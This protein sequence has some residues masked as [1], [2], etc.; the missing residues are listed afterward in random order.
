MKEFE[1]SPLRA[2]TAAEH[3]LEERH[4]PLSGK[5]EAKIPELYASVPNRGLKLN[6]FASGQVNRSSMFTS[7]ASVVTIT[8]TEVWHEEHDPKEKNKLHGSPVV[9]LEDPDSEEHYYYTP[10]LTTKLRQDRLP[11]PAKTRRHH[12]APDHPPPKAISPH[13]PAAND[14]SL[15]SREIDG[16]TGGTRKGWSGEKRAGEGE[17]IK[18]TVESHDGARSRGLA[19]SNVHDGPAATENRHAAQTPPRELDHTVGDVGAVGNLYDV[20]SHRVG[21]VSEKNG[22]GKMVHHGSIDEQPK[23]HAPVRFKGT[24]W[25][26]KELKDNGI[27]EIEA[28]YSRRVK[29]VTKKMLMSWSER[30]KKN[31]NRKEVT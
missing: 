17:D 3:H 13:H 10:K 7:T 21:V 24:V 14:L 23:L 29:K 4:L 15:A 18:V 6:D 20:A 2:K 28:P 16:E 12:P 27:I 30:K 1:E 26:V 8:E 11:S 25:V 9:R 22:K 5:S 31:I 19:K